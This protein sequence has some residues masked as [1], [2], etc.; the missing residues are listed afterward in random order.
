MLS[1][2]RFRPSWNF[3]GGGVSSLDSFGVGLAFVSEYIMLN[4]PQS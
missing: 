4:V 2:P 3:G 1:W